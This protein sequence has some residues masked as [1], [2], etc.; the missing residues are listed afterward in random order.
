MSCSNN[1]NENR[2]E[3]AVIAESRSTI[4]MLNDLYIGS[5]ADTEAISRIL[6]V[7]PSSIER[8]RS[9]E[10]IPSEQFEGRVRAVYTYYIQNDQSFAKLRN[11]L[12]S[13][14]KWYDSVLKFPTIHPW[15]FWG[16]NIILLLILAFVA[17]DA[18]WPI[19]IE[20]L[21]FLIAW[22]ASLV[23]SPDAIVDNYVDTINPAV[24]ILQ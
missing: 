18:I 24:E 5:D 17:L 16:I 10:T 12:D 14:F 2:S 1:G 21:I 6:K 20:M 3:F 11:L 8:I 19:L 13:E 23:C 22:I 15:W 9:G 7:T 4:D